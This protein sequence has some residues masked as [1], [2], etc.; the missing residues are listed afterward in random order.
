MAIEFQIQPHSI[1]PGVKIV[2][3]LVD[4]QIAGAI[5]PSGVDGIK[6]VSAHITGIED[7]PD[8]A[9]S[10]DI[11]LG[12]KSWPPVPAVSVRFTPSPYT[13]SSNRIIRDQS[14]TP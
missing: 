2:V 5:Y 13:I 4:G 7:D 9:G 8:F 3:I 1:L 10:V 6:L 11:D 12:D 14:P